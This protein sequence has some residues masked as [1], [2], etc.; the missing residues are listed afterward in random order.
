M[1]TRRGTSK[2]RQSRRSRGTQ[3]VAMRTISRAVHFKPVRSKISNDPPPISR[4][5]TGSAIVPIMISVGAIGS[6][7]V[8]FAAGS[9]DR[10]S[11]LQLARNSSEV[12]MTASLSGSEISQAL[13]AWMQWNNEGFETSWALRKV[14]LWGPNPI[15]GSANYRDAEIGLRVDLGDISNALELHDGGT[16]VRRPAV[17]IG[18]P[19]SIWFDAPDTTLITIFPDATSQPCPLSEGFI[20]GKLQLSLDWRRGP[21][22]LP[23]A[24][25]ISSRSGKSVPLSSSS[26]TTS[27]TTAR[28]R[29][30]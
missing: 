4:T 12:L 20:W 10:F 3:R 2:R 13:F 19:Y 6:T 22:S 18:L 23:V 15:Q 26:T 5:L 30:K 1:G 24:G 14:S 7:T 9:Y 29:G 21:S 25:G 28:G 8:T 17:A 27:T 11:Y 16:T